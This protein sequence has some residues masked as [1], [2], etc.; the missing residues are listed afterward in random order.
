MHEDAIH[1]KQ[2]PSGLTCYVI[3]KK[4]YVEKQAALAVCYGSADIHYRNAQGEKRTPQG[5]A[6]F[7]EHKLFE[8]EKMN[9][10]NRFTEQGASVNAYTNFI[11]TA[12]YFS[13]IDR[14]EDNLSLLFQFVQEPYFTHENVE[15]E[16][17]IIEQ[18]IRMYQDNPPW[19]LYI[20]LHRALYHHHPV[21]FDIAGTVESISAIQPDLLYQC[22][23]TFYTPANQV[24]V[25]AGDFETPEIIFEW[26]EKAMRPNAS[27]TA[28][29][30]AAPVTRLYGEEPPAA[31]VCFTEEA[32]PVSL[33]MFQIGYKS[34]PAWLESKPAAK[35]IALAH[36]LPDIIAGESS[37]LYA[38][39]YEEGLIDNQFSVAYIG[40]AI[41]GTSLFTGRGPQP[42]R[43]EE[44]LL[45]AVSRM[46]NEGIPPE[47]FDI[48][49][50]KTVGRYLREL[51]SLDAIVTTQVDGHNVGMHVL[52][53]PDALEK[54]TIQDANEYLRAC[55]QEESH[56]L[57][58]VRS[59]DN[60]YMK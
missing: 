47:R 58:V 10:F 28:A 14:F 39:M 5:T 4:G 48:I 46:K 52:S 22:Y 53:I 57:S 45:N 33:P 3:Q 41:W 59:M 42:R 49:K 9:V 20:N 2:L 13:S 8:S 30:T 40:G 21:R 38:A 11:N 7:L 44:M 27:G 18:E 50:R 55:F 56:A 43:V 60:S 1:I 29:L 23:E 54:L 24:F 26:A 16:K 34:S 51:N 32:M 37:P 25:C 31:A 17:G 19:R 35:R 15:K 12:Y 36:I 6:H